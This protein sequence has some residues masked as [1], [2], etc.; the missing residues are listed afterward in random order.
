MQ[1]SWKQVRAQ[2]DIVCCD[3]PSVAMETTG[4]MQAKPI[5]YSHRMRAMDVDSDDQ[6]RKDLQRDSILNDSDDGI[7]LKDHDEDQI[8]LKSFITRVRSTRHT[9][10]ERRENHQRTILTSLRRDLSMQRQ[11]H[12]E[13]QYLVQ[14]SS[15]VSFTRTC[16][17]VRGTQLHR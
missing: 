1:H 8:E 13:L 15:H 10:Q 7:E 6:R 12:G 11:H 2:A 17:R 5:P 3:C 4:A 14:L 9:L 16:R